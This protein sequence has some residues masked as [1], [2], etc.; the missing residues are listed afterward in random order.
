MQEEYIKTEY[1]SETVPY[2]KEIYLKY[3]A[4]FLYLERSCGSITDYILCWDIGLTNLDIVG[5][6][7]KVKCKVETLEDGVFEVVDFKYVKPG[8]SEKFICEAN[9]D[10]GEDIK[11]KSYIV[12]PPTRKETRYKEVQRERQVTAYR[13][14]IKYRIEEVCN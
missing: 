2:E 4:G 11:F 7:F 13:P 14:I 8:E 9:I 10:L 5:G 1:Y 6:I 3:E 12:E